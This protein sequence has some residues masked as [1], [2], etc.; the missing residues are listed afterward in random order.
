MIRIHRSTRGLGLALLLLAACDR[1]S[2]AHEPRPSGPTIEGRVVDEQ[3]APVANVCVRA[4]SVDMAVTPRAQT[5]EDGQFVLPAP[6]QGP[7]FMLIE[8]ED[9]EELPAG[10]EP[11]LYRAG[12]RDVKLVL[13]NVERTS[14][15]VLDAGSGKP[16]ER[17]G[18]AVADGP[19]RGIQGG[20]DMQAPPLREHE[21]GLV[22]AHARAG[23]HVVRVEA[24]GHAPLETA[25][26]LD[27]G[28]Q[29]QQT[30]RLSDG[31][32]LRGRLVR[33]GKGLAQA[34]AAIVRAPSGTVW[35]EGNERVEPDSWFF[36]DCR[37]DLGEFAGRLRST[38]LDA[39]GSFRFYDLA[40]GTYELGLAAPGLG[41]RRVKQLRVEAGAVRDLGE[42]ELGAAAVL[43]V[44]VVTP[45][46]ARA[47]ELQCA[48]DGQ[49]RGRKP[50]PAGGTL[51]FE[52]LGAG[53]HRVVLT[54][55]RT[56]LAHDEQ[57]DVRLA[58]GETRELVFE[59]R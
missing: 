27:P 51:V 24:P 11:E 6:A 35:P 25:V 36:A 37:P 17:Y 47:E 18:L 16:I 41:P 33:D 34:S 44:R 57:R 54:G 52:G 2:A 30:L 1:P 38:E 5:L 31:G 32:S 49:W 19:G 12:A 28:A 15:L 8:G 39:D 40:P 7:F 4:L 22:V 59:P 26:A 3:G 55:L 20:S 48:L 10:K 21:H 53:Q 9:P 14:F 23:L 46:G 29:R 42:L 56:I 13:K 58:A 50:F 45:P 43:R